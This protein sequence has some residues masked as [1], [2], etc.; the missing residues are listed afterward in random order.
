VLINSCRLF[1]HASSSLKRAQHP[2]RKHSAFSAKARST[3]ST[4]SGTHRHL[5]SIHPHIAASS[6]Y[7]FSNAHRVTAHL[8]DRTAFIESGSVIDERDIVELRDIVESNSIAE[9]Q[10]VA[11]L[12]RTSQ[13]EQRYQV[14]WHISSCDNF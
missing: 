10:N 14:K 12:H 8:S 9:L 11:E 5:P 4:A 2:A 7:Q 13:V 6:T 1:I 3:L